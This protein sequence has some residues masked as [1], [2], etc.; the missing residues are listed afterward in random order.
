MV[1]FTFPAFSQRFF[2]RDKE[3]KQIISTLSAENPK[4]TVMLGPPSSGKTALMRHIIE[5]KD[6]G[7]PL[8]HPL[9]IDLRAVDIAAQDSLFSAVL[10]QVSGPEWN[11]FKKL[12]SFK[13]QAPGDVAL[14]A[15]FHDHKQSNLIDLLDAGKA[16]FRPHNIW[17]GERPVVLVVDEANEL[18]NLKNKDDL[19]TFLRFA[20]EVSK[21]ESKCHVVFTSSD[22]FFEY[23]L[24]KGM[25]IFAIVL[26]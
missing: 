25:L 13:L 1:K 16:E 22:S 7:A 3:V 23:W 18:K 9:R 11:L 20:V 17:H 26:F 4:L 5:Q 24:E 10:R 6:N 2:N 15:K 14:T 8:F 12:K 21:Q 19:N